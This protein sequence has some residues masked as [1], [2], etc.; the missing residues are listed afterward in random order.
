MILYR[1][2]IQYPF[3][4]KVLNTAFDFHWNSEFSYRGES[5]DFGEVVCV[6]DGEVEVVEDQN[7]YL[8]HAGHLIYHA[9]ME[10]HRIRS[11]GD[12]HPHV[13]V[14]S[15]EHE[16]TLPSKL[17]DGVF[18]LTPTE[19]E[20]YRNIFLR[21]YHIINHRDEYFKEDPYQDAE[22]AWSL[23]AFLTR[24][25]QKHTPHR[26]LSNTPMAEEYHKI[27]ETMQRGVCE[28]L[29]L[30][31]IAARNAVSVSTIKNLFRIYAG[32]SPK[33]YYSR[34]RGSEALR[35]LT[36]GKSIEE[37]S[38]ALNFSSPCYFSLFF[39]KQFGMP[40]GQY[41]HKKLTDHFEQS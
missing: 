6:M 33:D 18:F 27:I 25:S 14:M 3:Q 20:E 16:G 23:S 39:K 38:E 4:I 2:E 8:L 34:L 36:K 37:I 30:P 5:H 13:M 29:T 11:F 7:V 19:L 24:L 9:P 17:K 40:P 12:T 1:F 21:F 32:I 22:A 35:L 28:N 15:F 41:R 10:F 31:E 26:H